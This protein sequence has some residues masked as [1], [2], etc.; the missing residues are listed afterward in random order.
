MFKNRLYLVF[1]FVPIALLFLN[2]CHGAPNCEADETVVVSGKGTFV[3]QEG[4]S[5]QQPLGGTIGLH[6]GTGCINHYVVDFKTNGGFGT[7]TIPDSMTSFTPES[8]PQVEGGKC[9]CSRVGELCP[10]F[11]IVNDI[12]AKIHAYVWKC[13]ENGKC[14]W[15]FVGTRSET[16]YWDNGTCKPIFGENTLSLPLLIKRL[17]VL[18]ETKHYFLPEKSYIP[19]TGC[20]EL[21]CA[22]QN[23]AKPRAGVHVS[24]WLNKSDF[25]KKL[26]KAN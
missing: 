23:T 1:S 26:K 4:N 3:S 18:V 10:Q 17:R 15:E 13:P 22:D 6:S 7:F 9:G 14:N 20:A 24:N 11:P 21:P 8:I 16:Y 2:V 19:Y 25:T 12:S 5:I